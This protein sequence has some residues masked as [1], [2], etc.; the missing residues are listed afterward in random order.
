M[1]KFYSTENLPGETRGVSARDSRRAPRGEQ[2][3]RLQQ[4]HA[5][6]DFGLKGGVAGTMRCI[7]DAVNL[8]LLWA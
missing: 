2:P 8:S 3:R 5:S 1:W 6:S 4:A 7:N